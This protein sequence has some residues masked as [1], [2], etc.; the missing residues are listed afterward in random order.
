VK[1]LSTDD[2]YGGTPNL[3][4]KAPAKINVGLRILGKRPDGYHE[5]WSVLQEIDLC[6]EITLWDASDFSLLL[7]GDQEAVPTDETNLCLRAARLL[8][9]ASGYS[10]AARIK[11]CKIIPAGAGLGGGSSDAAAVLKGLNQV[12]KTNLS[13]NDLESLGA[14][15]GSDVPFFLCGG[16]CLATGRGEKLTP[17]KP[18]IEDLLVLVCPEVF[19]PTEWAYKN[20]KNYHLTPALDDIIFQGSLRE[21]LSRPGQENIFINDFEPVVFKTYPELKTIKQALLDAGAYFAS[22]SGSGSAVFGLFSH[23]KEALEAAE[24]LQ[25]RWKTYCLQP[26]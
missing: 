11:L 6:D 26:R 3:T 19:V 16:C 5:I 1:D 24:K 15:L 8:K 21:I 25:P 4:L 10:G 14:Q 17:V 20:I 9:R 18:L 12:W 13:R 7:E 22:L 23:R 2:V